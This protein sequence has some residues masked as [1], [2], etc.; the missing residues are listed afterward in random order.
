[1]TWGFA[2]GAFDSAGTDGTAGGCSA[3]K[4]EFAPQIAAKATS[5]QS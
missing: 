2:F 5:R 3:R 4:T 1:M